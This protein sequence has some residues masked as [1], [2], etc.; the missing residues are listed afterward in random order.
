MKS[1]L[2]RISNW[3]V[4]V[5]KVKDLIASNEE[6]EA[7]V[8]KDGIPP[9]LLLALPIIQRLQDAGLLTVK[10]ESNYGLHMIKAYIISQ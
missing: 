3:A 7:Y 9:R 5:N 8:E 1:I 6:P 4:K 10:Y 2:L